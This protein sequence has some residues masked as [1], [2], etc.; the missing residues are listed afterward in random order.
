MLGFRLDRYSSQ[1][2]ALPVFLAFAPLSLFLIVVL[3]SDASPPSLVLKALPFIGLAGFSY[4]ASQVGADF[5]KRLEERLWHGWGGPP[6]TRFLR[7]SNT[8]FNPVVRY[9]IHGV[10][11]RRNL[12]VPSLDEER[13]DPGHADECYAT[14]VTYLR[15]LT[16]D[17]AAYPLVYK[18]LIDYGFRRNMYGL[19]WPGLCIS[20]AIGFASIT[21]AAAGPEEAPAPLLYFLVLPFSLLIALGWAFLVTDLAVY[22]GANRYATCLLETAITLEDQHV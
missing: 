1:A 18:R 2:E 17:K 6:T 14:C 5:G 20:L 15:Q 19:R 10:L 22:R 7:H 12:Q 9:R 3:P 13:A 16:R 11:R 8:E 21:Y 4:V